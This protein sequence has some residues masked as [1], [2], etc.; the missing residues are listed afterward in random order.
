L[1]HGLNAKSDTAGDR[2]W[3]L[4]EFQA[5][6]HGAFS[7]GDLFCRVSSAFGVYPFVVCLLRIVYHAR[8][9]VFNNEKITPFFV[10]LSDL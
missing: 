3:V 5:L 6:S 7:F 8:V 2:I 10:V 9:S 1:V 4:D